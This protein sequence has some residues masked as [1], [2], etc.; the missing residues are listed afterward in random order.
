MIPEICPPYSGMANSSN[1]YYKSG[2]GDMIY[3]E[4]RADCAAL[5]LDLASFTNADQFTKLM[6]VITSEFKKIS[7]QLQRIKKR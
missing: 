6:S 7:I 3:S 2:S 4:A 1:T 5:G